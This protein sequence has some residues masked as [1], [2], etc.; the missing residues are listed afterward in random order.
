MLYQVRVWQLDNA[1]QWV[2]NIWAA[3]EA[4]AKLKA[5]ESYPDKTVD[6]GAQVLMRGKPTLMGYVK[7]Q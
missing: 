2:V 6:L 4:D 5:I 7:L 3:S 1:H